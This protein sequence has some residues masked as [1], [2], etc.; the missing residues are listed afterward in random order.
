MRKADSSYKIREGCLIKLDTLPLL[1]LKLREIELL[2]FAFAISFTLCTN[3]VTQHSSKDKVLF[4][5]Q[6]I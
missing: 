2:Y 4:G 1:H 3:I 6:F 5:S